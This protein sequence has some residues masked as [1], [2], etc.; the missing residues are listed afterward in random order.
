MPPRLANANSRITFD[1]DGIESFNDMFVNGNGGSGN[2]ND[3][4]NNA[5]ENIEANE[6]K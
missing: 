1:P 2:D 3:N 5:T 4:Q 6:E